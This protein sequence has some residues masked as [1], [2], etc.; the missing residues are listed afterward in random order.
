M[1]PWL[2]R[3]KIAYGP[4]EMENLTYREIVF[5]KLTVTSVEVITSQAADCSVIAVEPDV[6]C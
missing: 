4:M 3:R 2:K 5:N 1:S 6:L